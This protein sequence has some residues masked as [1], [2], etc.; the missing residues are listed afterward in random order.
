MV[1]ATSEKPHWHQRNQPLPALLV[2]LARI[3]GDDTAVRVVTGEIPV[4]F[5]WFLPLSG[6]RDTFAGNYPVRKA[7]W[8]GA[9]TGAGTLPFE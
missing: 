3:S 2:T 8:Q 1:Y 7:A 9:P 6:R 5:V 4:R